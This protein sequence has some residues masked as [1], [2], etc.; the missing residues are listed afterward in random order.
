MLL[1]GH[2]GL[3]RRCGSSLH[4]RLASGGVA[5][6]E[7]SDRGFFD[8]RAADRLREQL[9]VPW[10][11][12]HGAKPMAAATRYMVCINAPQSL[13]A[14]AYAMPLHFHDR[15]RN[16]D[17]TTSSTCGVQLAAAD[18]AVAQELV[19]ESIGRVQLA[20]D[21]VERVVMMDARRRPSTPVG[22][23]RRPRASGTSAARSGT[24]ADLGV[25]RIPSGANRAHIG[26]TGGQGE[27][28]PSC[29]D[30]D[31]TRSVVWDGS[32]ACERLGQRDRPAARVRGGGSGVR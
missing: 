16:R 22:L 26:R 18:A 19:D 20:Q 13:S 7:L 10:P 28:E 8:P 25:L 15:R 6:H 2:A 21:V 4:P 23:P 12:A 1:L 14:V 3:L 32:A 29:A 31:R 30:V 5:E 27:E 17:A 24:P 11:S 9:R